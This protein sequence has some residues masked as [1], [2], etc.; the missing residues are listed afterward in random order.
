MLLAITSKHA[1][2]ERMRTIFRPMNT[3]NG[4]GGQLIR[5]DDKGGVTYTREEEALCDSC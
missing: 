4:R 3:S 1:T 2:M 5:W